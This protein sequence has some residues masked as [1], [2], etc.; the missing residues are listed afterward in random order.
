MVL[1]KRFSSVFLSAEPYEKSQ[2]YAFSDV[3]S[4]RNEELLFKF[5]FEA[6]MVRTSWKEIQGSSLQSKNQL[7]VK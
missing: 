7:K 5:L 2:K 3:T 1:A 6:K 4:V